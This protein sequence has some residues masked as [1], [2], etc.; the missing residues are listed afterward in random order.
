M[1]YN[2]YLQQYNYS[3]FSYLIS[4][5]TR[6]KETHK[7]FFL[8]VGFHKPHIPFK[9]PKEYLQLYPLGVCLSYFDC[10]SCWY[11]IIKKVCLSLVLSHCHIT[12]IFSDHIKNAKH[13]HKPDGLPNI[14]WTPWMDLRKR[15]GE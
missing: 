9:F 2:I 10:T 7:P 1:V 6:V 14:A 5:A 12:Q 4:G 15:Y 3:I 11:I 8:A 13:A